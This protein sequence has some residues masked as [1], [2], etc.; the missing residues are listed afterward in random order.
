M[1]INDENLFDQNMQKLGYN[2]MSDS[3]LVKDF[4]GIQVNITRRNSMVDSITGYQNNEIVEIP[5]DVVTK[6][7][8]DIQQS[9]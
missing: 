7:K 9:L 5:E 3:F 1:A 4:G 8:N 6:V 2:S